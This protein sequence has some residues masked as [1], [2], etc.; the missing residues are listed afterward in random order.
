LDAEEEIDMFEKEADG[1]DRKA[2]EHNLQREPERNPTQGNGSGN[3][4]E[5]V[6]S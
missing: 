4:V 2:S 6:L 1:E 5:L 3:K